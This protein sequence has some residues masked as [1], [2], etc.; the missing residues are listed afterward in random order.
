MAHFI[1]EYSDNLG[2][3]DSSIQSLFSGLYD[4]AVQTGIFPAKGLRFKAY[5]CNQYRIAD[6]NPDHGFVHLEVKLGVGR[7]LDQRKLASEV[8]FQAL[9]AHFQN[10]ID[11]RGMAVSFEMKELEAITK[12][13]QN[14]I[15]D[16]L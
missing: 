11:S 8:I 14:N 16:Y 3:D 13:N 10:L 2:Q 15:Q 6:G 4:A 5:P 1:L 7:T 12:F 9:T